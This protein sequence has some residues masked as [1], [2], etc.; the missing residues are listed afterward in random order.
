MVNDAHVELLGRMKYREW[1]LFTS[2]AL[3]HKEIEDKYDDYEGLNEDDEEGVS[4]CNGVACGQY[5][6]LT[7]WV[8]YTRFHHTH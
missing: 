6:V 4:L 2:K 3:E 8:S 7:S 5:P 1:I